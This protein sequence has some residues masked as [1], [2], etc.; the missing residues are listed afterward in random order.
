MSFYGPFQRSIFIQ[1]AGWSLWFVIALVLSSSSVTAFPSFEEFSRSRDKVSPVEV[2][3]LA[4]PVSVKPGQPFD[5]HL[6]VKLSEGWHIY[7]LEEQSEGESLATQIR[8]EENIFRAT[9]EWVEPKPTI[10]LD[11]ALDKVVKVHTDSVRFRRNLIVPN[12][13]SP[14]AYTISGRI[15]YRACDNKICSLPQNIDFQTRFQVSEGDE[16]G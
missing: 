14:G 11:G 6:L 10:A 12:D 9:G 4:D 16:G 13:L 7:A 1:R 2:T 8:F 5:L 15:E 3:A